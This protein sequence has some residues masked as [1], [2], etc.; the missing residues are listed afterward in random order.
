[1]SQQLLLKVSLFR[2]HFVPALQY[3][4]CC[5]NEYPVKQTASFYPRSPLKPVFF[6]SFF[7]LWLLKRWDF[8]ILNLII[9]E[10]L[11]Q[12]L[13]WKEINEVF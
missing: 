13:Q 7:F 8:V 6:V 5:C 1:M 12:I 10:Y 9:F 3:L 4:D 2:F 11:D